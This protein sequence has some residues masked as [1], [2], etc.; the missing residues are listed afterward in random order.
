MEREER[1]HQVCEMVKRTECCVHTLYHLCC[2]AER[3]FLS[4]SLRTAR[5]ERDRTGENGRIMF[6][7]IQRDLKR[8]D[9]LMK[10]L[11][12]SDGRL[13]RERANTHR[14]SSGLLGFLENQ[15][16]HESGVSD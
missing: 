5:R 4:F 10:C 1:C 3:S 7:A 14:E 6:T 16:R 2:Q 13:S 11:R 15:K 8:M 12:E 9:T